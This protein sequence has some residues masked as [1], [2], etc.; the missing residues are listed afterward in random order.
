MNPQLLS[1]D[2]LS[3]PKFKPA[4][5]WTSPKL[6]FI[7]QPLGMR[8]LKFARHKP[9]SGKFVLVPLE[10]FD[11]A[12]DQAR[13]YLRKFRKKAQ[14]EGLGFQLVVYTHRFAHVFGTRGLCPGLSRPG[15]SGPVSPGLSIHLGSG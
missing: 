3:Q 6:H 10:P 12:L 2:K 14:S 13:R 9:Y 15:L 8:K 7:F 5:L 1:S 11:N 4:V